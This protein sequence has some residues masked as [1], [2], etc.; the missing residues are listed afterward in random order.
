M[1]STILLVK[2]K[3]ATVSR[4]LGTTLSN[5]RFETTCVQIRKYTE[6]NPETFLGSKLKPEIIPSSEPDRY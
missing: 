4:I 6:F 5:F 2:K 3:V 1:F